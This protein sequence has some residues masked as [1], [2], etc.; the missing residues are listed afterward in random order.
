MEIPKG[1]RVPGTWVAPPPNPGRDT[2]GRERG[3]HVRRK[4]RVSARRKE[5]SRKQF[6]TRGWVLV[7]GSVDGIRWLYTKG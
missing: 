2:G 4:G 1:T 3:A 6:G 5:H 7:R